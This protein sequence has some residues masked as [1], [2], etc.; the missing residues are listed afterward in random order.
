[1]LLELS[2]MGDL[3][4]PV[5]QDTGA[6]ANDHTRRPTDGKAGQSCD[7]LAPKEFNSTVAN[8]VGSTQEISF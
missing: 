3:A 8:L 2:V 6:D 4:T 5:P 7:P 1:M